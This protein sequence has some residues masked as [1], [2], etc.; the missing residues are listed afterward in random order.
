MSKLAICLGFVA[1]CAA[2][3]HPSKADA[4]S[5]KV[6]SQWPTSVKTYYYNTSAT[7][8]TDAAQYG[9]EALFNDIINE[10]E[11]SYGSNGAYFAHKMGMVSARSHWEKYDSGFDD[12]GNPDKAVGRTLHAFAVQWASYSPAPRNWSDRSGPLIKW[13]LGYVAQAYNELNDLRFGCNNGTWNSDGTRNDGSAAKSHQDAFGIG[14]EYT[15]LYQVFFF[16]YNAVRRASTL[17][18]EAVHHTSGRS[19]TSGSD[20]ELYFYF[21]HLRLVGE[22]G[23]WGSY[24]EVNPS[25][26]DPSVYAWQVF[27]LMSYYYDANINTYTTYKRWTQYAARDMIAAKFVDTS[28]IPVDIRNF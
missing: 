15:E 3:I 10:Y 1:A 20:K 14:D 9:A 12:W 18:H 8:Y 11:S 21:D 7:H 22:E 16:R 27:W 2:V 26:Q 17:F 23:S 19:H 13:S 28:S 6:C 5:T 24:Y 25:P 4:A